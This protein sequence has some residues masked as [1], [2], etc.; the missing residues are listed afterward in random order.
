MNKKFFTICIFSIVIFSLF[1]PLNPSL[2]A[3]YTVTCTVDGCTSPRTALFQETSAV[4]GDSVSKSF[5]VQNDRTE[6]IHVSLGGTKNSDTDE[7]F[8][9]VVD[10]SIKNGDGTVIRNSTLSQFLNGETVPLGEIAA[11]EST[12]YR[13]ILT[14]RTGSM[15]DYQ[16]KKAN[17]TIVVQIQ[18]EDANDENSASNPSFDSLQPSGSPSNSTS[19]VSGISAAVNALS[20]TVGSILGSDIFADINIS[21]AFLPK[22]EVL[23]TANCAGT[24]TWWWIPLAIQSGLSLVLLYRAAH[25][26]QTSLIVPVIITAGASALSQISHRVFGCGCSP[27]Y[28]CLQ[29]GY[30]NALIFMLTL[31]A[32]I[33][34]HAIHINQLHNRRRNHFF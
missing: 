7:Q 28:W 9:E 4:P 31:I 8:L 1:F 29:Y 20:T 16:G 18:G 34:P 6:P 5:T 33:V 11:G 2:A 17:F 24:N 21:E 25:K 23:G 22:A 10:V 3:D 15:N 19:S 32:I 14:F 12:E 13:M 27:Q 26:K 30:I